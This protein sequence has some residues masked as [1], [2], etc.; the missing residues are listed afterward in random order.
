MEVKNFFTKAEYNLQGLKN[1]KDTVH[2]MVSKC[3]QKQIKK[4]IERKRE[5]D[6][7]RK[8]KRKREFLMLV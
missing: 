8:T 3:N 6:R 2:W 7:H 5:T 4:R 1:K